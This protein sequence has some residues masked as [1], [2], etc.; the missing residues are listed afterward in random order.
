MCFFLESQPT[1]SNLDY[2]NDILSLAQSCSTLHSLVLGCLDPH[3]LCQVGNL[4][5]LKALKYFYPNSLMQQRC[6]WLPLHTACNSF[7]E[8]VSLIQFLIN[9]YPIALQT[10]TPKGSLPL[11]ILCTL[12]GFATES[13]KLVLDSFPEAAWIRAV[14]LGEPRLQSLSLS[15][16]DLFLFLLGKRRFFF[17]L[18]DYGFFCCC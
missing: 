15:L 6:G 13:I 11:H 10:T 16:Y 12:G 7:P 17:F 9:A 4:R 8:D 18:K 3:H 1:F 2:S 14:P 5:L